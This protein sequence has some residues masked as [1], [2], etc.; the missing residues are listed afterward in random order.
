M[1]RDNPLTLA[2][3]AAGLLYALLSGASAPSLAQTAEQP[4]SVIGDN[5]ATESDTDLARQIQ[6]PVGD[7]ISLPLRNATNFG[8]GPH[9]AIQNVL[10]LQPVIPFHVNDDWKVITRTMLPIV[11]N[12]DLSPAS[13]VPVGL[14]PTSFTAFLSPSH[15]VNG[16]LWVAGPVVQLPLNSSATLG[17]SV[18][19]AGPSA[20]IVYTRPGRGSP[21]RWSTTSGR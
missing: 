12:P 17:S 9:K 13:T 19:G 21:A 4:R 14:A 18:W 11:W 16:W 8:Y 5:A 3:T 2:A 7:L 6:N 15:D 10:N 20:V 1:N